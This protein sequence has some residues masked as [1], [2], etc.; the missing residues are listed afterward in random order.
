MDTDKDSNLINEN[1]DLTFTGTVLSW[2][3]NWERIKAGVTTL[4]CTKL[5]PGYCTSSGVQL[6]FL[7]VKFH[8]P[9]YPAQAVAQP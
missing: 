4:C 8:Q 2:C 3:K 5:W 1:D 9:V 7:K 6:N